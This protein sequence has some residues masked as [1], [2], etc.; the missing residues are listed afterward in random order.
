M[1]DL[2]IA[3]KNVHR[4][5]IQPGAVG[6]VGD[7]NP[8][9]RLKHSCPDLP[10]RWASWAYGANAPYFGSNVQDGQWASFED[11][12]AQARLVNKRWSGQRG[13]RTC[14]G[15]KVEDITKPDTLVE[16]FVSSLGDYTWRNR[17]ATT[18]EARKT[19]GA[20]SLLPNGY[21]LPP[22]E[23]SRGGSE[24]RVTNIVPG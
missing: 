8:T 18:Y 19:G 6:S 4:W 24:V 17:I 9:P 22:G 16:P 14:V 13:F 20:F 12:G 11:G 1:E 5:L 2:T 3:D 23:I 15:W 10:L 21:G 7:V